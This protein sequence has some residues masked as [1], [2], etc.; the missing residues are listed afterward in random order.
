MISNDKV[1]IEVNDLIYFYKLV[2]EENLEDY[3]IL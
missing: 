2:E 1:Y 3:K